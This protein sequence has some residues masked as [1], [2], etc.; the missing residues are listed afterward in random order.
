MLAARPAWAQLRLFECVIGDSASPMSYLGELKPGGL[1]ASWLKARGNTF[2]FDEASGLLYW[3]VGK[4]RSFEIMP[5]PLPEQNDLIAVLSSEGI[6][7]YAHAVLR[8]R[9]WEKSILKPFLYLNETD[10]LSGTCLILR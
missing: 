7:R 3:V 1:S 8:I 2:R 4:P 6:G 9:A 5:S 10:I